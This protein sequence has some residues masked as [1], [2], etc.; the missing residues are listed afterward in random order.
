MKQ[1]IN[2]SVIIPVFNEEKNITEL[3]KKL[4]SVLKK[5]NQ[6]WEIIVINDGSNDKSGQILNSLAQKIKK[7]K[8]IHFARNFGQT[9]AIAAG[10]K[11][12]QGEII[13]LI[14]ADLQNDP[15]DI[16]LLLNKLQ[17]GYDLV[18]GWRK[19][20]KDSLLHIIPSIIANKI[21]SLIT[22]TKLHDTGCTLKVYRKSV[23]SNF[24]LYGEMHRFLPAIASSYG[25]KIA[26][27]KVKHHP[28]KCGKSNYGLSRTLKVLL[29][30][31]TVKFF[32][33][34]STKPIYIFG[35][36]GFLL[37]FLGFFAAGFVVIRKIFFSGEWV[38][39]MLFIAVL[40]I[41]VSFQLILMGLLAEIMIRTYFESSQKT[42][43]KIRNKV[44]INI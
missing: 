37:L 10:V 28:R 2:L 41:T 21:I 43:Y 4:T 33:S 18:S 30:L 26:E 8:V 20:R 44:N 27:I 14:D 31:L 15:E 7:L 38:S 35:G 19:S 11:Y 39:P 6:S 32:G 40:L 3:I 9:A 5:L 34:F 13:S 17:Q 16:P 29:D 23:F 42:I 25:A 24:N 22:N 12:S 36:G 1:K